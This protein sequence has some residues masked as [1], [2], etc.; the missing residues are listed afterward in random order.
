M[1]NAAAAWLIRVITGAFAA[2]VSI[3]IVCGLDLKCSDVATGW[4][5][6][7]SNVTT[8]TRPD[9]DDRRNGSSHCQGRHSW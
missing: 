7:W 2:A 3:A 6:A 4:V 8:V 9:V 1:R 5:T